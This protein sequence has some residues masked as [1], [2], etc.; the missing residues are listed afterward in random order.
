MVGVLGLL[1][2]AW[3]GYGVKEQACRR[4]VSCEAELWVSQGVTTPSAVLLSRLIGQI[5]YDDLVE[6]SVSEA[7]EVWAL[8]QAAERGRAERNCRA[9]EQQCPNVSIT[10]IR[11]K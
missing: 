9:Y 11:K 5:T 10:S 7:T 6:V 4:R 3:A 8:R 1:E 2:E